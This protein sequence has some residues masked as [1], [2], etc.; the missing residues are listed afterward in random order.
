MKAPIP[1]Q[2]KRAVALFR[3]STHRQGESGLGLEAQEAVVRAYA[4]RTGLTIIASFTEIE[5]GTGK[6]HRPQLEAALEATRRAGATLVISRLDR[7][8]RSVRVMTTLMES[9]VSFVA[10]DLPEADKLVLQVM[11]AMAEREAELVSSRT[12]VALAARK[13]RGLPLGTP[14]NFTHAGRLLGA[15]IRREK[16][17]VDQRQAEGLAQAL[18]RQGITFEAI[19]R[20]LE[21]RGYPTVQGG[22]WTGKQVSRILNRAAAAATATAAAAA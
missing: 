6:R 10:C 5:T 9:G 17:L 18:R 11:C 1:P 21:T 2:T 19:A 13:A 3:V 7:M 16:A 4:E 8:T 20:E 22:R 15:S 14:A 12:K